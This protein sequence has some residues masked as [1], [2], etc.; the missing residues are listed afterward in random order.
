MFIPSGT[1]SVKRDY[2]LY[3]GLGNSHNLGAKFT[4][5]DGFGE[6]TAVVGDSPDSIKVPV[7][8]NEWFTVKFV[9]DMPATGGVVTAYGICDNNLIYVKEQGLNVHGTSNVQLNQVE[10]MVGSGQSVNGII[11]TGFDNM[12]FARNNTFNLTSVNSNRWDI[13]KVEISKDA[14]G[15]VDVYAKASGNGFTSGVL[16]MAV[17]DKVSGK[18]VE[19]IPST[20]IKNGAF[21]GEV[22]VSK[23]LAGYEVKAFIFDAITTIN[24]LL[25][26]GT[27][28]Y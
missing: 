17:Y 26:H 20:T 3:F 4:A 7:P 9:I 12:I 13:R 22:P 10:I 18:L 2:T 1:S 23:L 11:N 28:Q 21:Q 24:P 15:N 19:Y 25:P 27:L 16:V 8:E 5:V 6:F 14:S